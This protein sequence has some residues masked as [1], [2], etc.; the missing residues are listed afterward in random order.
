VGRSHTAIENASLII[1]RREHRALSA[2][3][4]ARALLLDWHRRHNTL[5]AFAVLRAMLF[6]IAEFPERL[7]HPKALT[8]KVHS[9]LP[10]ARASM[11]SC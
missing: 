1:I 8:S 6:Y 4:C 9:R 7:H 2:M 3:L 5:P 10:S 11:P